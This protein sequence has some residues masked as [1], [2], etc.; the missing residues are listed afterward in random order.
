MQPDAVGVAVLTGRLQPALQGKID[1]E[2]CRIRR[3]IAPRL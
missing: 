1:G 3:A 2:V